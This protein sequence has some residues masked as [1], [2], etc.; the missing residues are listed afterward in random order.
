MVRCWTCVTRY[1]YHVT[2]HWFTLYGSVAFTPVAQYCVRYYHAFVRTTVLPHV[3]R[4]LLLPLPHT[5]LPRYSGYARILVHGYVTAFTHTTVRHTVT[6]CPVLVA[7]HGYGVLPAVYAPRSAVYR[8]HSPAVGLVLYVVRA[9]PGYG[10]TVTHTHYRGLPGLPFVRGSDTLLHT[11]AFYGSLRFGYAFL[12][13][14]TRLHRCGLH[15]LPST[16]TLPL[17]FTATTFGLHGLRLRSTVRS[18]SGLPRSTPAV[19]SF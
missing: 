17:P 8:T 9:L 15:I 4:T 14:H 7:Y 3:H 12:R 5:F 16:V 13:L 10:Y 1:L 2:Y 19:C 18:C 11:F 6:F